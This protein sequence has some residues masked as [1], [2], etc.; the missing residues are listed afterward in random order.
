LSNPTSGAASASAPEDF[1]KDPVDLLQ[2]IKMMRW[3]VKIL[4]RIFDAIEQGLGVLF[5][6][7]MFVSVLI[8]IFFRY[9]L[10]SPLTW[11]EEA[12]RYSFIWIVLLG[13]A[14]AVRTKEHVV[15]EVLV[16]RF[17]KPLKT[18]IYF[19]LNVIIL[20][21]LI[22]LL[23]VSWNFFWFIKE[24]SAPTLRISWGFLFFSAPLSIAL[25][26]THTFIALFTTMRMKTIRET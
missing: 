14:F 12:S 20:M 21:A 24:V 23:P 15:M 19:G 25:M 17:P 13:A 4:V 18:N 9:V 1:A 3:W 7:V 22:Y 6:L 11:T 26:T 16:N 5:L 8:Q 10:Q 2:M